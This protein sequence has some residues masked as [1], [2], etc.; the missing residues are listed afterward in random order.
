MLKSASDYFRAMFDAHFVEAEKKEVTIE[1]IDGP[2]LKFVVDFIYTCDGE[3]TSDNVLDIVAA[4][5]IM[6]VTALEKACCNYWERTITEENC[7]EYML[8]ADQYGFDSLLLKAYQ[9]IGSNWKKLSNTADF[10]RIDQ[11]NLVRILETRKITANQ[12]HILDGVVKWLKIKDPEK[13][14][15]SVSLLTM[16][17]LEQIPTDVS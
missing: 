8:I 16:I 7:I 4:A 11:K 9:V 1:E 3:I 2:T 14:E 6:G 12:K 15:V 5:T 17:A 10:T 13:T